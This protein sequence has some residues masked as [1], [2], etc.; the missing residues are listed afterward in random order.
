MTGDHREMACDAVPS[1]PARVFIQR[2][3]PNAW[4][5]DHKAAA[6][7]GLWADP[8]EVLLGSSMPWEKPQRHGFQQFPPRP[9]FRRRAFDN[10]AP[11]GSRGHRLP[12]ARPE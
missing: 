8:D 12:P 1:L 11:G 6:G 9:N 2:L 10:N 7:D 5:D 3:P 4:R